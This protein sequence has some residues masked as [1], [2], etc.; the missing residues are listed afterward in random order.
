MRASKDFE[1]ALQPSSLLDPEVESEADALMATSDAGPS[2]SKTKEDIGS[3]LVKHHSL[4]CQASESFKM[5]AGKE[6]PLKSSE[7][8]QLKMLLPSW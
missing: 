6:K 5:P 2:S 1:A 8:L 7:E 3:K 4:K